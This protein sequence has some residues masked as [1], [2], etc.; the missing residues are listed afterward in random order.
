MPDGGKLFD[1][2]P[3]SRDAEEMTTLLARPGVRIERIVSTGQVSSP[4]FWY[5]QEE[6][7]WILIVKGAAEILFED[8]D[9]PRKLTAGD[10]VTITPHRRH[11]V[12]WTDPGRPTIWLAIHI[13]CNP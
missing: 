1:S 4:G 13:L 10:Y 7:E 2:L 3:A 9:A 5:D 12:T 6:T 11:R 8:E